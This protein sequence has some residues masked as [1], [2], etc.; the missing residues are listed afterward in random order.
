MHVSSMFHFSTRRTM[1]GKTPNLSDPLSKTPG[2][3]AA[4]MELTGFRMKNITKN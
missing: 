2:K 3:A 1:L 4:G